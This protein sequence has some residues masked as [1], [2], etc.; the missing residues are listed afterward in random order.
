M[1]VGPHTA[2]KKWHMEG[3]VTEGSWEAGVSCVVGRIEQGPAHP[4]FLGKEDSGCCRFTLCSD[5]FVEGT[6][7]FFFFPF[8]FSS[9]P[10]P[11]QGIRRAP[12]LVLD[13]A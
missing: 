3:D 4:L 2:R 6:T 12:T 9:L 10:V 1:A 5:V 11:N 7:V 13:S 8:S